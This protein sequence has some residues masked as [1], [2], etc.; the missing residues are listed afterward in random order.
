MPRKRPVFVF[1]LCFSL[2]ATAVLPSGTGAQPV[3]APNPTVVENQQPGDGGWRIGQAGYH[4]SEDAAGQIKGYA[5]ATSVNK[6]EPITFYVT[7]NPA[8]TFTVDIYRYGWYGGA[9]GRLMAH[10]D[11]LPGV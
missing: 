11:A 3:P 2:V 1:M 7:V 5:S 9:G 6:G 4:I 10:I 8:Q